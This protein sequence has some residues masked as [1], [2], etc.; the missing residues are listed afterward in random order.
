VSGKFP[1]LATKNVLTTTRVASGRLVPEGAISYNKTNGLYPLSGADGLIIL[2]GKL[3]RT[4]KIVMVEGL[5]RDHYP[6]DSVVELAARWKHGPIETAEKHFPDAD[7]SNCNGVSRPKKKKTNK[8]CE[9][10]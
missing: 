2:L 5:G 6:S 9:P 4:L 10:A 3:R 7:C 1:A 8:L